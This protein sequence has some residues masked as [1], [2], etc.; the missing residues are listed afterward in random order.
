[1]IWPADQGGGKTHGAG[2]CRLRLADGSS[3][4]WILVGSLASEE[5]H[6]IV[7]QRDAGAYDRLA[8]AD[9][10]VREAEV[11]RELPG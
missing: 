6:L 5:V 2:G 9:R 3:K 4:G 7:G 1:M 8:V 11:R 10:I